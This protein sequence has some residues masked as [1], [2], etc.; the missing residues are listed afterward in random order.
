MRPLTVVLLAC[1]ILVAAASDAYEFHLLNG[2]VIKG[3]LTAFKDSKFYASTDFGS[4][5]I[6]ADKLDYIIVNEGDGHPAAQGAGPGVSLVEPTPGQDV[7]AAVALPEPVKVQPEPSQP[8][9]A[10]ECRSVPPPPLRNWS[11]GNS[12]GSD[13]FPGLFRGDKK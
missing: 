4:V 7:Q 12:V 2:M 13:F 11:L 3:A 9:Q 6:D 10:L 8:P 1:F 5:V